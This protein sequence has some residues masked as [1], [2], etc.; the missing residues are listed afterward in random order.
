M[1][2][3][4]LVFLPSNGPAFADPRTTYVFDDAKSFFAYRR[5]RFDIIFA[6]PS[7]PWVSGTA[8]L[9]TKEF[10]ERATD[11]LAEGGV[12][13]QWMQIY[14]L[15]DELF[16]SVL[17][18]LDQ[19]FPSYRAY[20]VGDSDVAIVASMDPELSEPDWSVV[21][22]ER[23]R[24]MTEGAPP[25]LPEH[26][27]T[28]FLFDE[29][30]FRP[31]LDQGV[32]ANSDYYPILDLGAERA[33]FEQTAADGVYSFGVSPVDLAR[34]L[35]NETQGP[36]PYATVPF[37]GLESA[38]LQGRASWLQEVVATGGGIAPDD[39]PEW[40]ESLLDLETLLL[41]SSS[42][43]PPILWEAWASGFDRVTSDLHWGTNGWADATFYRVIYDFLDRTGAPPEA[44]AAVDLRH[45]LAELDWERVASASDRLV[46][47][48]A[49][50]ESWTSATVLLD[51]S[52]LAYLRTGRVTA[53]RSALNALSPRTSRGAGDLRIRLLEALVEQDEDEGT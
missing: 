31:I 4:S 47:R 49:A 3:G 33:R 6:E 9:F 37:R 32:P 36:R 22:S 44:R 28:L 30:T 27:E 16:L 20:L 12:L 38:M 5:E 50:G 8:S 52:V 53:A 24:Q 13:A 14:E 45:G 18:A 26:M 51:A 17:S 40:S 29:R 21:A 34:I 41:Q 42:D 43:S 46:S 7:N 25:F 35:A 19:V 15:N 11:F 2:E 1:V 23:A 10:Y 48:V 39:F